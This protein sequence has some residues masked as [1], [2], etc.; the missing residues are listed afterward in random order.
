MPN[1]AVALLLMLVFS[2]KFRL[3][4]TLGVG[5]YNDPGSILS[6][7]VLP[8]VALGLRDS[9][10]LSR[11]TRASMMNLLRQDY[12]TTARA[13]GLSEGKVILKHALKNAL[14]G[15]ITIIS[16]EFGHI[17]GS[18]VVIETVF[19]RPGLGTLIVQA[20]DSR[21]YPQLQGTLIVFAV[22]IIATNLIADLLYRWADPR[23]MN[24]AS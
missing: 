1:F 2:L 6:H 14:V 17:L 21:D 15:T 7:L 12:V 18:T 8:A 5:D 22:C 10:T 23:I 9:A 3:F 4:P 11:M 20:I 19:G 24:N 16:L 13:K